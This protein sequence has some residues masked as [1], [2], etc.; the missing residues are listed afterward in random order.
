MPALTRSGTYCRALVVA[1]DDPNLVYVGGG[2]EFDGDL[3]ALFRSS[4][5]GATWLRLDLGVEPKSPIFGIGIDARHPTSVVCATKGGETFYSRD[6]GATWRSNPLP[7][8][9]TRVYAARSRL[10]A[11]GH[12]EE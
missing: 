9:A 10:I 3:G 8:G 2:T 5:F 11:V 7:G 1:P 6:R 12:S 4:D